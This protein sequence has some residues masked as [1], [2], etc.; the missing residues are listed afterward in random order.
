VAS[1]LQIDLRVVPA[2]SFGAAL[3]YFTG[4]KA[5]NIKLRGL[6]KDRGLKINE[7]GVFRVKGE[8][9]ERI[10]GET[11]ED[12]YAVLDL[13]WFPPE[14]REGRR[15]FEWAETGKLP[16]L[17]ELDDIRGDL[18]MHT[19]ASDGRASLEQ[20]AQAAIA[21]GLKY[22]AITDHSKRVSMARGLDE[23]R[24]LA[25]WKE[26]DQ[27][28]ERL[29]K[30]LQVLKGVEC[31]I[32]EKGGMDISDEVLSQADWVVA[33]I[34]YGQ[35]QSRE[36]ITQRILGAIENPHVDIIAH[37][38]G[39][40]INHRESY[41][42]DLDAVYKAARRHG[43]LLELNAS[44]ERLD[45]DDVHCA[46]AKENGVLLVISTDAHSTEGL[47]AMRYGILQARRAGLTKKDVANT[48]TWAQFQKLLK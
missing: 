7:Y 12:V 1:G 46:A 19:T 42:V 23:K 47:H 20:M 40:L 45:L 8:N 28:N 27:L 26:V 16:E 32:L 22:I 15:E 10:A 33:S 35:K 43:T 38:T 29:G 14:I 41:A 36:Q 39:R 13:P 25:Q 30:K 24:L 37:P 17:I 21:Q 6:A 44:P 11:E 9:E 18:H 48:R 5:H 3:Q 4:S 31:D 2:E 34:H